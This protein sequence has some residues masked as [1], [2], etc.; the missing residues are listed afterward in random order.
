MAT[1]IQRQNWL[2]ADCI[3]GGSGLV[4]R[5]VEVGVAGSAE[6]CDCVTLFW[7]ISAFAEHV[8]AHFNIIRT[9]LDW[10]ASMVWGREAPD[11]PMAGAASHTAGDTPLKALLAMEGELGGVLKRFEQS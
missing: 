7:R 1:E 11:S 3:C 9:D 6:L 4:C 8:K 5:F 2:D 10:S